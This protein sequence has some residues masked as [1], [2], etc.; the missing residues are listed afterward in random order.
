MKST[1]TKVVNGSLKA[2]PSTKM[3]SDSLYSIADKKLKAVPYEPPKP[4]DIDKEGEPKE[5]PEKFKE[6]QIAHKKEYE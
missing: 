1:L 2:T 3:I 6:R 4:G 5:T